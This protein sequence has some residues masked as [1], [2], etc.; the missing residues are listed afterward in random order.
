MR[1]LRREAPESPSL[2]DYVMG[3]ASFRWNY[4]HAR[5]HPA[6]VEE[7]ARRLPEAEVVIVS[8][9]W[10][11]DCRRQLPA[12]ARIAERIPGWRHTL[13][14]Y[15]RETTRRFDIRAIPTFILHDPATG[16]E[17]ARIVERPRHGSLEVDLLTLLPERPDG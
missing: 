4:E 9:R 10:C 2:H 13:H 14:D 12:W 17:L 3:D 11:G 7:I 15:D 8:A 6:L 5:P 1:W 16:E